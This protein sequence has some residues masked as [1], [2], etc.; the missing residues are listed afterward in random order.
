MLRVVVA[1]FGFMGMTHTGNLLKNPAVRLTA[2]ADKNIDGI[3]QK[4]KEQTGNFSTGTI[5]PEVLSGI[6]F[7]DD[8]A[9]C[10]QVEKPDAC[11]IAVH[12]NLH[13][14]LA[15]TALEAG[16]HVFL[17]K[18]FSLDIEEGKHLIDLARSRNRILMVGHVVRFMPAYKMLKAGLKMENMESWS[19]FPFPGF[20]EYHRGV[21]G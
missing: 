16:A 3:Q 2:V 14:E 12:T 17:E 8:F 21:N 9:E 1:G 15:K 10:L 19:F 4:L 6:K 7:Y 20:Q 18:P 11:I 5:Q 13:Y